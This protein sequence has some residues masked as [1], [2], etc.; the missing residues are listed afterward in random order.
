MT[1]WKTTDGKWDLNQ[2]CQALR[3]AGFN[4]FACGMYFAI[5]NAELCERIA[6]NTGDPLEALSNLFADTLADRVA[7]TALVG[8]QAEI[9]EGLLDKLHALALEFD[10][11]DEP[12]RNTTT[13]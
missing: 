7:I 9:D 8:G 11:S 13:E 5:T 10:E 6:T 3:C 1:T 12:W 2:V 4:G